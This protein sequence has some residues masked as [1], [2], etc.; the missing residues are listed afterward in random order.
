MMKKIGN[1]DIISEIGIGSTARVYKA[2]NHSLQVALKVFDLGRYANDRAQIIREFENEV[3]VVS[4]LNHPN[5]VKIFDSGIVEGLPY[6]AMELMDAS[7]LRERLLSVETFSVQS[8]LQLLQP[9]AGA[10]DYSH[11][12]GVLHRDLKPSNVLFNSC[13]LAVVSDFS[14]AKF[15]PSKD[16]TT[17]RPGNDLPGTADFLAPEV[18]AEA[19]HSQSSDLYSLGMII[20]MALTGRL[21][22]NGRTLFTRSRDRVEGNLIDVRNRNPAIGSPINNVVMRALAR[23]PIA[24]FSSA[25]EFASAFAEAAAR[26]SVDHFDVF[27]C[28][29]SVDKPEVRR[30]NQLLKAQSL[31]TWLEE[32]QLSPGVPW[33]LEL[34]GVIS[35]VRAVAICVGNGG[36]GPWQDVEIRAFLSEFIK[37]G[38]RVIPVI[39]PNAGHVPEL[40]IFLRQMTWIDLRKDA[41]TGLQRLVKALKQ[42]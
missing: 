13:S 39:L 37:R 2:R 19:P 14:V 24:R 40:P 1:Y 41:K 29:N 32:E 16:E 17:T 25:L 18:L 23:D 26:P 12:R 36:I 38:C 34:E 11:S 30:I 15:L 9:I 31:V 28:H 5:I 35:R 6:I 10:L 20:Y 8:T 33:Q 21:P 22:S 7:S 3:R 27:L 42:K 4:H